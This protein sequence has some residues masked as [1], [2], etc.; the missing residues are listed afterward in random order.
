MSRQSRL[1]S[2]GLT[3]VALTAAFGVSTSIFNSMYA[4]Q[5]RVDAQL[6]NGADVT[7]ATP[8]AA[9]LPA[10]AEPCQGANAS[11]RGRSRDDAAPVRLR[12]QRPP[13]PVRDSYHVVPFHYV[14]IVREFPTAPHDSFLVANATYVA[15]ATGSPGWQTMLIKTSGPPTIVA[16]EVR[17]ELG[18][19]SG[20]TVQDIVTQQRITL[21]SLTAIDLTGLTRLE[22]AFAFILAMIHGPDWSRPVRWRPT[23]PCWCRDGERPKR[24]LLLTQTSR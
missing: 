18:P 16:D 15:K 3:N 5:A 2:R 24:L 20:A 9:E 7:A 12:G 1:L 6:T 23:P 13:G 21:S 14:G 10:G 22:L 19:A 8:A 11:R 4:A 17:Q